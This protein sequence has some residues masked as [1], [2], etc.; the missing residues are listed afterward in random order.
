M[1]LL[2]FYGF[3]RA[4]C[5]RCTSA[6]SLDDDKQATVGREFDVLCSLVFV[7]SPPLR[8]LQRARIASSERSPAAAAAPLPPPLPLPPPSAATR[9][10]RGGAA[11]GSRVSNDAEHANSSAHARKRA[12][13]D[14]RPALSS[15][16]DSRLAS[17]RCEP[18]QRRRA[19]HC[20]RLAPARRPRPLSDLTGKRRPLSVR[21]SQLRL[22]IS[23]CPSAWSDPSGHHGSRS[24]TDKCRGS[25]LPRV[26]LRAAKC[27]RRRGVQKRKW[28]A[29]K[30]QKSGH[31]PGRPK[32]GPSGRDQCANSFATLPA[33]RRRSG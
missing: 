17:A 22:L 11:G 1:S 29:V 28:G 6:R 7:R 12:S 31:L 13:P 9:R 25:A 20:A 26:R 15:G 3:G 8:L 10:R 2:S 33:R 16:G 21:W 4:L 5:L 19:A 27:R 18:P 23:K 24:A 32:V 14:T 30:S